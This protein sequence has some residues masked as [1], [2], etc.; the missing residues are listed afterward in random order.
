ML[1]RYCA[2]ATDS[3]LPVIVI[4]RSI[5]PPD[6]RSSQLEIRIMAPLSCLEEGRKINL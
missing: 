2:S 6:S 3:G 4:V 5:F 1:I